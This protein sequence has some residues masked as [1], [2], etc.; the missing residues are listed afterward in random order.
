MPLLTFAESA[1]LWHRWIAATKDVTDESYQ[2]MKQFLG[3]HAF[4][5]YVTTDKG[6]K[7]SDLE[8]HRAHMLLG[9]HYKT[10]IKAWL[11]REGIK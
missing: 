2:Q 10:I 1:A 9:P 8:A 7:V 6:Y 3:M 4:N 11:I 5:T